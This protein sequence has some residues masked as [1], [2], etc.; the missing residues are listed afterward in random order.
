V[1]VKEIILRKRHSLKCN[2]FTRLLFKELAEQQNIID[3]AHKAKNEET[4]VETD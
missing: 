2:A 3:F 4:A 1:L